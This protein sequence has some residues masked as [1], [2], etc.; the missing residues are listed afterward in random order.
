[1][2]QTEF[3]NTLLLQIIERYLDHIELH[4]KRLQELTK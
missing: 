3:S 4:F 1:M 2:L